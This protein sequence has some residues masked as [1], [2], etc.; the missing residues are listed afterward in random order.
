MRDGDRA[1]KCAENG[2]LL[3][4][5]DARQTRGSLLTPGARPRFLVEIN[6]AN[7]SVQKTCFALTMPG[8]RVRIC[9]ETGKAVAL[10]ERAC[11]HQFSREL[12]LDLWDTFAG[13]PRK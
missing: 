2:R 11:V 4:F 10:V 6:Q 1:P 12:R 3:Q 5:S 7:A 8:W 13:N 9:V